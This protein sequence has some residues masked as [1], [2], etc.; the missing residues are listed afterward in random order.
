MILWWFHKYGMPMNLTPFQHTKGAT[1]HT[2][3]LMFKVI[4]YL[5][6]FFIL[7]SYNIGKNVNSFS[8]M[9]L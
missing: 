3:V 2:F 5:S 8:K 4:Q 6:I 7:A 1:Q 9:H